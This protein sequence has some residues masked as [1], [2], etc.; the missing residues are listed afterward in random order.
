V[1]RPATRARRDSLTWTLVAALGVGVLLEVAS[2]AS[3]Q[4][5]EPLSRWA[6]GRE[7]YERDCAWCHGTSGEGTSRGPRLIGTGAASADF[8]LT[9][10]RMPIAQP[11]VQPQ[12]DDPHYGRDEIAALVAFVGS[13]GGGPPIPVVSPRNGD[14]AE[15][16][17]LY[18]R[19]C[20]ACHGSTGVGGAL[21][22]GLTAPA[23]DR[24][25]A[26][27]IAEAIRIGG[28]GELTGDMPKFGSETLD[29]E[30]LNAVVRY[31]LWL[32]D[33]PDPGGAPLT[34]LGPVAEGF[35]AMFGGVVVSLL[36]IRRLGDRAER[37]R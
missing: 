19:N 26:R 13:L 31:T 36:I 37:R 22:S 12:R 24:A 4:V 6:R 16:A 9:T 1:G 29:E 23:L 35:V 28:S 33:E 3:G 20:A 30:Q 21:T 34:R 17:I 32:R 2:P 25:T 7:L 10:G 15:G 11:E 5:E 8:M 14:L 18:E 27:Q